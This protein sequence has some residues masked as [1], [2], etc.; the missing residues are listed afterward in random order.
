MRPEVPYLNVLLCP[1]P[2]DFTRKGK[3]VLRANVFQ[4]VSPA[5]M[6]LTKGA[7]ISFVSR[8]VVPQYGVV[9]GIEIHRLR[10]I[11]FVVV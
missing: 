9:H 7:W 1:T 10:M 5:C 11:P 2:G 4:N 3:P 8:Q 6:A